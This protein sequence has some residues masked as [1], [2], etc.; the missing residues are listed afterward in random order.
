MTEAFINWRNSV[1]RGE[2]VVAWTEVHALSDQ[3]ARFW[4][5]AFVREVER[6]AEPCDVPIG[7]SANLGEAFKEAI[8]DFGLDG[9]E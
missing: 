6:R 8:R 5:S 4:L 1:M 2:D 7:E 3:T 9:E